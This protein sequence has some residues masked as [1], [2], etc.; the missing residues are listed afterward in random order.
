MG[1]LKG[2]DRTAEGSP[3]WGDSGA[4]RSCKS[5]YAE[6][7][8]PPPGLLTRVDLPPPGGDATVIPRAT[9]LHLR[10]RVGEGAC[11]GATEPWNCPL[12]N[13]APQAGEGRLSGLPP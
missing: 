3:G 6:P 13:F 12:P 10:G 8:S 1:P 9:T 7:L 11:P 2:E 4:A 5:A